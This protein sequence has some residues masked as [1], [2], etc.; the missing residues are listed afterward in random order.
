MD[1]RPTGLPRVFALVI[2]AGCAPA[3]APARVIPVRQSPPRTTVSI[4]EIDSYPAA[5]DAIADVM[6][7]QLGFPPL[8]ASIHFVPGREN[9]ERALVADGFD[10]GIAHDVVRV[11]DAVGT[12]RKVLVNEAALGMLRWPER[13]R[14][15]A[16]ELTHTLQYQLAGGRRSTSD[17]WLREGFADWVGCRVLEALGSTRLAL[18]RDASFDRVRRTARQQPLPRLAEMT[19]FGDWMPLV[20]ERRLVYE[21]ALVATDLLIQRSGLEAMILYFGRFRDSD[22]RLANFRLAFGEE[23][24]A[25]D[26]EVEES[27]RG[28]RRSP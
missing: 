23:F 4:V 28:V 20:A 27:I 11:L 8:D 13:V 10:A 7:R 5:V 3:F 14:M 19:R 12:P 15:L 16:H 17:Q 9:L 21:Q 6:Q 1:R 18:M 2:V 22:D 24:D 25:F 26:R